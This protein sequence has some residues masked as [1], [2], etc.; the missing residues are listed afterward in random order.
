MR[1]VHLGDNIDRPVS[2]SGRR[3]ATP[4]K[5][6]KPVK[7]GMSIC[8]PAFD[9]EC[10]RAGCLS[11]TGGMGGS[12]EKAFATKSATSGKAGFMA[13]NQTT[14]LPVRAPSHTP[15]RFPAAMHV[16]LTEIILRREG[17]DLARAVLRRANTSSAA[18]PR[19]DV[20]RQEQPAAMKQLHAFYKS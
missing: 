4:V 5:P 15:A 7:P 8:G 12:A 3:S 14:R 1:R 9:F 11:V 20:S 18:A 16:P 19:P 17:I 13:G 10:G 2:A 6:V